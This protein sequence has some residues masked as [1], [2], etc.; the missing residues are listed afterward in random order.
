MP[1][2][3]PN[4]GYLHPGT[5]SP[6]FALSVYIAT[7]IRLCPGA[8]QPIKKGAAD[9]LSLLFGPICAVSICGFLVNNVYHKEMAKRDRTT[10][11]GRLLGDVVGHVLPPILAYAFSARRMPITM[12]AFALTIVPLY[13]LT[14]PHLCAVYVGMPR[15]VPEWLAPV[16]ALTAQAAKYGLN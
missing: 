12:T 4:L 15:W 7:I 14:V 2:Y 13:M 1:V 16:V 11:L 3:V 5:I 10:R 8:P 6:Y 9:A